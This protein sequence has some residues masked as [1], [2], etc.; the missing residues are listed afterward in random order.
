MKTEK[1]KVISYIYRK[2]KTEILVFTHQTFPEAGV[3]VVG[4][5]LETGEEFAPSLVREILEESGLVVDVKYLKKIGQTEYH[6]QDKPEINHRHYFEM[7]SDGLPETWT[8]VV[9]SDG[10]DNG[11]LFDFFWLT[12]KE[13]KERLVGNFGELL[14]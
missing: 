8:H 5:T 1:T 3:Q 14:R 7:D 10:E 6:R 9:V 2:N 12:I 4:G 11:L 13:A